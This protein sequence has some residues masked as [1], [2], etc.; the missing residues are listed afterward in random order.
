MQFSSIKASHVTSA[1]TEEICPQLKSTLDEGLT[2][3]ITKS[4][5]FLEQLIDEYNN[6]TL[7]ED[8]TKS[9]TSNEALIEWDA[10]FRMLKDMLLWFDSFI[11][12][13]LDEGIFLS[14][15]DKIG[16]LNIHGDD[17]ECV[18]CGYFFRG[19]NG[20]TKYLTGGSG[21]IVHN[22]P[23]E[24]GTFTFVVSQLG[25]VTIDVKSFAIDGLDTLT[26]LSLKPSEINSFSTQ[27]KSLEGFDLT[28][29]LH[30]KVEP[31]DGGIIHGG[32]LQ[33]DFVIELNVSNI[34]L[35]G[36]L[37]LNILRD[38]FKLFT[39]GEFWT[40]K[41]NVFTLGTLRCLLPSVR[42]I[43]LTNLLAEMHM[44][45]ISILPTVTKNTTDSDLEKDLDQ[46][47]NNA[48]ALFMNEYDILV[49]DTI[50]AITGLSVKNA[51]N[52]LFAKLIKM[53]MPP[54]EMCRY[55]ETENAA[56]MTSSR[57]FHFNNSSLIRKISTFFQDELHLSELNDYLTCIQSFI[58][59]S[60]PLMSIVENGPKFSVETMNIEN[61]GGIESLGKRFLL[62]GKIG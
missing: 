10:D 19:I 55:N 44:N 4:D 62:I 20:L 41:E 32:A 60:P 56:S 1:L 37:Q 53:Q 58:E 34:L 2:Q 39:I 14:I 17:K 23:S 47:M 52:D 29:D 59:I 51:L 8:H 48:I 42:D 27:L 49:T 31:V 50:M 38:I 22:I 15:L 30:L 6:D 9:V 43:F 7:Q 36:D 46:I 11:S 35:G 21:R 57:F 24:F 26:N 54:D 40:G 25:N 3:I 13:H 45:S 5:S 61:F 12:K 33:E 16:W 18:D 28:V